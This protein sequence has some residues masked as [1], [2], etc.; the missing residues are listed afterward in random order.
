MSAGANATVVRWLAPEL[1]AAPSPVETSIEVPLP[2]PP[3]LEEIQ[4]IEEAAHRDGYEAGPPPGA[5]RKASPW[6]RPRCAA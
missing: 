5:T 4:A 3:S 2:R 6:A 1:D